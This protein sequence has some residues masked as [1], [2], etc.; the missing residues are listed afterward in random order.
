MLQQ[1]FE[2]DGTSSFGINQILNFASHFSR[3]LDSLIERI[4]SNENETLND[5]ELNSYKVVFE[6]LA[7]MINNIPN[8]KLKM[9]AA[10]LIKRV[11]Q[12]VDEVIQDKDANIKDKLETLAEDIKP[13]TTAPIS[14]STEGDSSNN[15]LLK[16][17]LAQT[18]KLLDENFASYA[19]AMEQMRLLTGKLAEI[20][21]TV[22]HFKEILEMLTGKHFFY[23]ERLRENWHKLVEFFSNFSAQIVTGFDEK[24]KSFIDIIRANLNYEQTEIDHIINER[25]N[26]LNK[27]ERETTEIQA[28]ITELIDER[29]RIYQKTI[30]RIQ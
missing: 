14:T 5:D 30:C 27:I 12:S 25:K 3:S 7:N 21:L 17:R 8:N 15:E 22:I 1:S 6:T 11:V 20:D 9:K 10:D 26:L 13:L 24:L 19:A 18:E 16:T 4:T 28:K 29:K 2:R 23:L